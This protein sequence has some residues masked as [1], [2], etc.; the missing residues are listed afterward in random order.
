ME[1][2]KQLITGQQHRSVLAWRIIPVR[3][4]KKDWDDPPSGG[5]APVIGGYATIGPWGLSMRIS[6]S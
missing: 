5:V 1:V 6:G 2:P 4:G 3:I